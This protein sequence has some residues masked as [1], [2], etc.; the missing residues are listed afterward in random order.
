MIAMTEKEIANYHIKERNGYILSILQA[1][2][3]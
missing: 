3:I 2:S 1:Q